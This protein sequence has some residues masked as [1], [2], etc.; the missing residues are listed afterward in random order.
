[1]NNLKHKNNLQ[2]SST[3]KGIDMSTGTPSIWETLVFSFPQLLLMLCHLVISITDLWVAGMLNGTV[4]A[5]L[6]IVS[7]ISMILALAVSFFI[8][9]FAT[10]IAQC[11]GA[12]QNLRASRYIVSALTIGFLGSFIIA[13]IS[14]SASSIILN[15][16]SLQDKELESVIYTFIIAYSCHLPF[17]TLMMQI[18][19]IFRAYKKTKIPVHAVFIVC[20]SNYICTYG[21]G[22]G[23]FGFTNYGYLGIAWATTFS[24]FL[25]S[26]YV[27]IRLWLAKLITKDSIPN[28]A[29]NKKALPY[30]FSIGVPTA[31]ASLISQSGSIIIM[32][33]MLSFE[34]T[35]NEVIA[36]Y[37]VGLRV[38]SIVLF[39]IMA[40]SISVS[41][42]SGHLMGARNFDAIFAFG[43]KMSK[44]LFCFSVFLGIAIYFGKSLIVE[45][46]SKD[47]QVQKEAI[48]F[49]KFA[50]IM[51][52]FQG[53]NAILM[54]ILAGVGASRIN[55]IISAITTWFINIP[56][57]YLFGIVLNFGISAI[58]TSFIITS[59]L[60]SFIVII[61]FYSRKWQN[62]GLIKAKVVK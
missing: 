60:T 38:Q 6:G 7:Q 14:I 35:T 43:I 36:G 40:F 59:C 4:Q 31:I 57:A 19:S 30:V 12:K 41:I 37:T 47:I 5:A 61:L 62:Y 33:I 29:W 15:K 55:A 13:C 42:L 28:L 20:I 17:S 44:F 46:L 54:G 56:I 53:I 10:T 18:N 50:S 23:A 24:G 1:M 3:Y 11:L 39:M 48:Y 45:M 32:S 34:G 58:Y 8:S 16:L 51:L 2:E 26:I 21:F 27:G 9:G 25:G 22:T 49:I 52:P